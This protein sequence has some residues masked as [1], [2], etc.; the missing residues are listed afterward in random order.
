M[1]S[2]H[3]HRSTR[4]LTLIE[5][6]ISLGIL[7]F[8]GAMTWQTIA[9]SLM[10][11]EI[12]EYE[13]SVSRSAR[14]AMDQIKKELR[15]AFLTSNIQAVNTY[16]TVFIGKDG[17]D[18]DSLWFNTMAHRRKY[19]NAREGD[20]A[21]VTLWADKG[22]KQ[23]GT[24]LFHRES[25]RVDHEPERG[26]VVLPMITHVKQFNLRYL[27]GQINE[28]VE[29]WDSTGAEQNNRLP[30]AVEIT[31]VIE[32]EHPETGEEQE[33]TFLNTVV[34]E[35]ATPMQRSLLAGDGGGRKLPI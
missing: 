7:V 35:T 30:R 17:G 19:V 16:Q 28:W 20:Q 8:I 27:D 25:G 15:V 4:G 2:L 21:E 6:V 13:D 34:L 26:G 23:T 24:V 10:L 29:E 11:R 14:V 1:T 22:T 31:L 9:G 18:E 32:K 12:L 5:V 33:F 3:T